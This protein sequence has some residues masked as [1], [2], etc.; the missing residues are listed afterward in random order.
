MI[1]NYGE[2]KKSAFLVYKTRY[3]VAKSKN[4]AHSKVGFEVEFPRT[5]EKNPLKTVLVGTPANAVEIWRL[6][7]DD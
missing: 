5:F 2:D 7:S 6:N 3:D 1:A 4:L